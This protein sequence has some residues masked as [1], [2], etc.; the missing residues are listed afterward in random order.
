MSPPRVS[1]GLP[2]LGHA[3]EFHRNP[4]EFLR[5]GREQ[6][7]EI[8]SF[9]LAG[10]TVHVLTEPKGN[11]AFFRA[12]DDQ[13]S[14]REAYQFTVP[15]FGKG[16]AYDA[17]P[18][19]MDEQLGFV[20]PA[21]REARMQSYA[22]A[23]EEETEQY[24]TAWG[25]EG[26][27]ELTVAMNEL[28]VFNACRCLIGQEFRKRLSAE[29]AHSYHDLEAGVNLVAF[30][31][32][33]WPLPAMRR[34]D[35]GRDN[36]ARLLTGVLAE[37]RARIAA[38]EDFVDTLL[39]AR[40]SDGRALH[41]REIIGLLLTLIFAGQH[42][43][44]VMA[45]WTG[46]LLLQQPRY[47]DRVLIE[48]RRLPAAGPLTVPL[49]KSLVMLERCTKEAERMYPPLVMLMRAILKDFTYEGH[50]LPAGDL[51]MIAPAVTHRLPQVFRS[52]D[53]YDP[54]R[55]SPGRDE[56]RRTQ[57]S[58]IG[59]GG[60]KHRCLGLGFAYQQIKVIWAV[61]LRQFDLELSAGKY[62]PDYSTFVVGPRTPCLLRY[63]RK[64]RMWV[65]VP[66]AAEILR[67]IA[68]ETHPR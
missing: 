11:G 55:F 9:L 15:M 7:G 39:A 68:Q 51:A 60:G 65:F 42:T 32:P 10:K 14:A 53:T 66:G 46:I 18:E 19:L 33:D 45:A 48:L 62:Q 37:R 34:R 24:C 3:I 28:T 56:D 25:D 26:E 5:R 12:P 36:I 64:R 20:I 35:R 21:L 8:F 27:I 58:L 50:V 67:P 44:A 22:Q 52:P 29:F 41:D 30:F 59:F 61:L 43:S 54:D 13:L 23:I 4:V 16:V 40:Y 57:F 2:L 63:R 6:H 17:P 1:G 31:K 38:D 49:L 47:L